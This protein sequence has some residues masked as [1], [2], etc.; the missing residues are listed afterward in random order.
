MI[1]PLGRS[2]LGILL[3]SVVMGLADDAGKPEPQ[4]VREFRGETLAEI[5]GP[6]PDQVILNA[7]DYESCWKRLGLEQAPGL[8]DFSREV[9]VLATTRGSRIGFRLQV[10]GEGKLRVLAIST[11]DIR[12]GLRYLFGVFDRKDWQEINGTP[13]P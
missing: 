8:V 2:L 13:L 5:S 12:P 9:V 10:E 4:A 1:A 3:F 7:Q 11:R 6:V